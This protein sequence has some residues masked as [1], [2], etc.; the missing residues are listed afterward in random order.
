MCSY[1]IALWLFIDNTRNYVSAPSKLIYEDNVDS[2]VESLGMYANRDPRFYATVVFPGAQ[3]NGMVYNS[4]PPCSDDTPDGYCSPTGDAVEIT[5]FTNTYTGYT[6]MK[7]IDP[8]DEQDPTNS[9]LNFIKMRYAGILLIYA[10]AKVELGEL[11][12]SVN[13][14]IE[15]IRDR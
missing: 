11:D 13:D 14:V 4:Y 9:G 5:D 12:Q 3:F 15:D 10:E 2:I 6:A 7:Y 1:C 8:Q